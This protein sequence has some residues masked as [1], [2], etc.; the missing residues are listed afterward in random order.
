[1]LGRE[2]GNS[3]IRYSLPWNSSVARVAWIEPEDCRT[4]YVWRLEIGEV[5]NIASIRFTSF[6]QKGEYLL[7]GLSGC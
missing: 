5:R 7:A 6:R 2:I 4:L 1:M 3:D